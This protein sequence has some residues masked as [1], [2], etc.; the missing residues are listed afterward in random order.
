[1]TTVLQRLPTPVECV[2]CGFLGEIVWTDW[3]SYMLHEDELFCGQGVVRGRR[4]PVG[5]P[6]IRH[7]KR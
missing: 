7:E 3:A 2:W 5:K 6:Q 1:V 4:R